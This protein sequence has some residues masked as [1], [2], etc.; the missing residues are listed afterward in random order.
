M[1]GLMKTCFPD[2]I[3]GWA[4]RLRE[5]IPSYGETLNTRPQLAEESLTETAEALALT[6]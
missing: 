4:P 1:L 2:Q 6:A 5:L 3:E